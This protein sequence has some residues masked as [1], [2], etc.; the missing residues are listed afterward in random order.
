MANDIVK[1]T[2]SLSVMLVKE[3]RNA[4]MLSYQALS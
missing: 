4:E 2:W 3:D 1:A